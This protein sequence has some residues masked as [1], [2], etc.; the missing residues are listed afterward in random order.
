MTLAI[1]SVEDLPGANILWAWRF[2]DRMTPDQFDALCRVTM[3]QLRREH[4]E[5]EQAA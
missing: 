4:A 3:E 1:R 2:A 5:Q